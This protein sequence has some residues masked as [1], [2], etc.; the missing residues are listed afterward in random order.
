M[1]A[2]NAEKTLM[3]TYQDVPKDI[4]D[5]II[6]VDDASSD[7]TAEIAERLGLSLFVHDHNLGYGGN[8]K[9]CYKE[10]IE[11]GA[12]IVVMTHPDYQYTPKLITAMSAMIASGEFDVVLGSRILGV[13][14][15]AG[16]M[17]RHKYIANRLLTFVQNVFLNYKLSEYHTGFRAFSR[18][19]L[20]RLPLLE[21]SDDFVFDNEILAQ[22]IYFGLRI[23]E[24]SCPTKYFPEASSIS[25]KR[26]VRYGLGVLWTCVRF[27]LH[28]WR[29]A[30]FRI[31]AEDGL[32][33]GS[34]DAHRAQR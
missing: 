19:A 15:L 25:F 29:L 23:G 13:G 8:Q 7:A 18:E 17:P 2:F 32:T 24:I 31:F 11:A 12:D 30:R 14:A 16:G 27:V 21:N 6:L 22:A 28:K 5:H 33:I 34:R 10:A 9:T 26:S 3:A 4:V 1:P 20:L